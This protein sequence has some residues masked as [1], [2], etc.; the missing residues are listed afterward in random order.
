[1]GAC[2]A[3]NLGRL[4]DS[5]ANDQ[6]QNPNQNPNKAYIPP[7]STIPE[8]TSDTRIEMKAGGSNNNIDQASSSGRETHLAQRQDQLTSAVIDILRSSFW[9]MSVESRKKLAILTYKT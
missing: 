8:V 4:A 3:P 5:A 6:N 9:G 2:L 1:M 7:L